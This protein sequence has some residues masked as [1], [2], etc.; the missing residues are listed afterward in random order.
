M[1]NSKGKFFYDIFTGKIS[2]STT[3]TTY[4]GSTFWPLLGVGHLAW[5][6]IT[7]C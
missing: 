3:A 1:L 4:S 2:V 6:G 7:E 5:A